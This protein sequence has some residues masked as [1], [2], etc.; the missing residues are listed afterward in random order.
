MSPYA[1]AL[2]QREVLS[3]LRQAQQS[4]VKVRE[5]IV[6]R[7]CDSAERV[8]FWMQGNPVPLHF[9]WFVMLPLTVECKFLRMRISVPCFRN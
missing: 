3:H 6:G 2:A 8:L 5:D 9:A 4:R 7:Q 1:A